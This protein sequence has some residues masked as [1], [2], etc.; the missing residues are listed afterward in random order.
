MDRHEVCEDVAL[1]VNQAA[2]YR[3][4]T[5]EERIQRYVTVALP[6]A[7]RILRAKPSVADESLPEN[8]DSSTKKEWEGVE[9]A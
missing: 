5:P 2:V 6:I 8:P 1:T 7:A 9:T 3:D 4:M